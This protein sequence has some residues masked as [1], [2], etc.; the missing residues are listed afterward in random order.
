MFLQC[1]YNR[2]GDSFRS[3]WTNNYYPPIEDD[4]YEPFFP[5]GELAKFEK[6]VCEI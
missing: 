4:E 5:T 6:E 2:D 1:D 3:P